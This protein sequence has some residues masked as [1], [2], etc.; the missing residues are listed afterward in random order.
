[1]T[2]HKKN[3]TL[4]LH[5]YQTNVH[6]EVILLIT[7]LIHVYSSAVSYWDEQCKH[8]DFQNNYIQI[9]IILCIFRFFHILN[10]QLN[11]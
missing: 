4:Q 10:N 9:S 5:F 1:M 8:T 6:K 3:T 11:I 7:L 2:Q